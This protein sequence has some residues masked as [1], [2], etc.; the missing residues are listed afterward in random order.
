[1]FIN[2]LP[3]LLHYED[4]NSMAFSIEARVPYL[5]V[6]LVNYIS[7]LAHDQKIR[8]GVTK[9]VLRNAIKGIVPEEIRNRMDKMGFV[10]P[11]E[12]WMRY[13]LKDYMM[14]IL[15]STSFKNRPYW[16]SE[17][18][19]EDYQKFVAGLTNYSPEIWRIICVELW[20]RKFFD[21]RSDLFSSVKLS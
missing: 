11:E 17:K 2:N 18:V 9:F 10:T 14:D 13:E 15:Y 6:E 21:N 19:L 3:S 8:N 20:L 4:R 12:S 1:M 5:E 16:N 7:S